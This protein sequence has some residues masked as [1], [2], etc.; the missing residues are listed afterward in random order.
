MRAA[1][2]RLLSKRGDALRRGAM[3]R[4]GVLRGAAMRGA[5][6]RGADMR[7]ADIRGADTRGAD[8]AARGAEAPCLPRLFCA[9]ASEC[10]ADSTM[11]V[12]ATSAANLYMT[13]FPGA[14][15]K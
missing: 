9:S 10:A 3:E 7:G 8:G 2:G 12:D 1:D 4:D 11:R 13:Q 5:D 15:L 6:M 14:A